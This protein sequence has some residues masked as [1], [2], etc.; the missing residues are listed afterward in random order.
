MQL[1]HVSIL[2]SAHQNPG[3]SVW[4]IR[5]L[6]FGFKSMVRSHRNRCIHSGLWVCSRKEGANEMAEGVGRRH[7]RGSLEE[8]HN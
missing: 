4:I 3:G 2:S 6:N 7:G 1:V 5:R 8:V